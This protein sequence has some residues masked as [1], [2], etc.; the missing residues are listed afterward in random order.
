MSWSET[1]NVRLTEAVLNFPRPD[2]VAAVRRFLGL[3]SYYRR[4]I[5]G[6]A[7]I[8]NPLHGLTTKN[9]TFDWTPKCEAAFT[10]LKSRLA[11]PPVLAYPHFGEDFTL[12]TDALIQG[13]G[14]VLS[15][16]QEDSR[17]HPIAYA[18]RALIKSE[19]NYSVT[20]LGT[21]AVVWAITHFWSYLYG[22]FVKVLTDHS[23]IKAILETPNPTGK[24]ARW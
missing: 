21:L 19:K 4:F 20:E 15:Q 22:N 10:T 8:A 11:T 6:F 18:S 7:K 3:A 14:A 2:D 17:L 23:A 16:Q 5:S 12:E 9:A 24:H 1:P 13:L